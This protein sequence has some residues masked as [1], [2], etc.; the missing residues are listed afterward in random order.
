M[1]CLIL[2][3]TCFFP[4]KVRTDSLVPLFFVQWA[5]S[6]LIAFFDVFVNVK[7]VDVEPDSR[8]SWLTL[9]ETN[10]ATENPQF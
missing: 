2:F 5:G 3:D 6:V 1:F 10:I 9:P 8:I 7:G 4:G